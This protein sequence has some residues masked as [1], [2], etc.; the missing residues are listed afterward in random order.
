[1]NDRSQV[2]AAQGLPAH[3]PG[4]LGRMIRNSGINAVGTVFNLVLSFVA[5]FVLARRL[6]PA[7]LGLY[8]LVFTIALVVYFVLESGI[9]TVLTRRIARSPGELKRHVSEATG[10]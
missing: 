4:S 3:Q 9:T 6:G 1:M 7:G 2:P 8:F 5:V 10:L